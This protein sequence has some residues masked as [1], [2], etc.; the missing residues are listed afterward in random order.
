L[1][2]ENHHEQ[3]SNDQ[4]ID[5]RKTT[6]IKLNRNRGKHHQCCQEPR[7]IRGNTKKL[8]KPSLTQQVQANANPQARGGGL[9]FGVQLLDHFFNASRRDHNA[10]NQHQM[11]VSIS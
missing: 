8:S 3:K 2:I 10:R 4:N 5:L 9:R 11:R 7:V 1:L 6:Q